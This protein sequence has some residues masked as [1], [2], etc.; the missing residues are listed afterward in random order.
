[1]EREHLPICFFGSSS[2][3]SSLFPFLSFCYFSPFD[4]DLAS[5]HPRPS[6]SRPFSSNHLRGRDLRCIH[7]PLSTLLCS[8][9]FIIILSCPLFLFSVFILLSCL[10]TS[11]RGGAS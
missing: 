11:C 9:P 7:A 2:H 5:P 6:L 4:S 3:I 1:M 8:I 10:P